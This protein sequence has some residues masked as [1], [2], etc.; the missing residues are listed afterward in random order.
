MR[1]QSRTRLAVVLLML[2]ASLFASMSSGSAP[3]AADSQHTDEILIHDGSRIDID[4]IDVVKDGDCHIPV[5]VE[6]EELWLCEDWLV[7]EG[8]VEEVNVH[9]ELVLLDEGEHLLLHG[10][11]LVELPD[12]CHIQIEGDRLMEHSGNDHYELLQEEVGDYSL[13]D[14]GILITLA[15]EDILGQS[16]SE[17]LMDVL[18]L[19]TPAPV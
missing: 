19:A 15:I 11:I 5:V 13:N 18:I 2:T 16:P 6:E 1:T 4:I 3:V 17:A 14:C 10:P 7:F 12:G 8:A 9:F